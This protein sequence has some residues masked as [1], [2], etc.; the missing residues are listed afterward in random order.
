MSK[1]DCAL[2]FAKENSDPVTREKLRITAKELME[3]YFLAIDTNGDGQIQTK[4]YEVF[5]E[6]MAIDQSLAAETFAAIDTDGDGELSVDEF[7]AAGQEFFI[8][9]DESSPSKYFWGAL[10]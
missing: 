6:V 3:I 4:E 1:E 5:F 10:I 7:V 8:G 2:W 9:E